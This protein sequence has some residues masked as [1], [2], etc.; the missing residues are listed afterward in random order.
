[1]YTIH[2]NVIRIS[3]VWFLFS[4]RRIEG[5]RGK[6]EERKMADFCEEENP[7]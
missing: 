2:L 4:M 3:E 5:L 7:A 1:M 6:L